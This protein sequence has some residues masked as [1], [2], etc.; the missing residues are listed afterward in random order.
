M[1]IRQPLEPN[2]VQISPLCLH[3]LLT[4]W[5]ATNSADVAA[6]NFI[7]SVRPATNVR[8]TVS[9]LLSACAVGWS[10]SLHSVHITICNYVSLR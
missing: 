4:P 6:S 5:E 8:G 2:F 1:G 10:S 3:F 7:L 9:F